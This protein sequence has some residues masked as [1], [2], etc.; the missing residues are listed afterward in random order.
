MGKPPIPNLETRVL[1]L[2]AQ[3]SALLTA[4]KASGLD[5]QTL[6]RPRPLPQP[7]K[8]RTTTDVQVMN[9]EARLARQQ[10][11]QVPDSHAPQPGQPTRP[12]KP[13]PRENDAEPTK[14]SG[15]TPTA[16]ASA[17]PRGSPP[18]AT[19]APLTPTMSPTSASDGPNS[20]A[21]PI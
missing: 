2:E 4:L 1:V 5:V 10:Q 8:K 15:A 18:S 21:T 17:P 20:S 16:P 13:Q 3:V 12:A 19:N 11:Q 7:L 6:L 9:R 14:P